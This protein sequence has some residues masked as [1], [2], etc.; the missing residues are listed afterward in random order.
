M[1]PESTIAPTKLKSRLDIKILIEPMR[2]WFYEDH[3][4]LKCI[5]NSIESI[6]LHDTCYER[7][8]DEAWSRSKASHMY[9]AQTVKQMTFSRRGEAKS[10]CSEQGTVRGTKC[11]DRY[12]KRHQPCHHTQYPIT[13]CL[14]KYYDHNISVIYNSKI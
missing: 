11:T 12:R 5:K 8:E 6:A 4:N 13:E 9:I 14:P 7:M 2:G 10:A 3:E 1:L